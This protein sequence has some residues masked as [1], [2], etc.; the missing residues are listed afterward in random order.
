MVYFF[1]AQPIAADRCAGYVIIGRNYNLGQPAEVIQ[2]F[3]DTIFGQDQRVVE[4]QRP[5][6]VPVRPGGR[7]A[8]EVRRCGRR[9]PQGHAVGRAGHQ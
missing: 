1:A 7:A 4:S 8:P 6:R 5:E 9:L 3:E 2:E